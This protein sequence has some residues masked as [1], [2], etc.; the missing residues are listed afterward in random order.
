MDFRTK[1]FHNNSK[2]ETLNTIH[3]STNLVGHM[4]GVTIGDQNAGDLHRVISK[5]QL[6]KINWEAVF[7]ITYNGVGQEAVNMSIII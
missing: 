7:K 3:S 2:E 1:S 4:V 6:S 5:Q